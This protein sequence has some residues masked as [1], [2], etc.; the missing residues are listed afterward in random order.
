MRQTV[1]NLR[2]PNPRENYFRRTLHLATRPRRAVLR[3]F[4]DTTYELFINGRLAAALSEW[5]NA[6]DY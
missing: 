2:G 1:Q 5:A 6:R 4:A 3:L